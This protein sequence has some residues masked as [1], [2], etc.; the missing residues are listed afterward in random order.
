MTNH[1]PRAVIAALLVALGGCGR[2]AGPDLQPGVLTAALVSPNGPEGAAL[3]SLVGS[4]IGTVDA[5]AGRVFQFSQGDTTRVLL[6]LDVPGDVIFRVSVPNL[7]DPPAATVTQVADGENRLRQ[8][9]STYRVRFQ[10]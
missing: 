2:D 9:V 8:D 4:G 6:I 3:I 7:R 1:A 10:P 5:P